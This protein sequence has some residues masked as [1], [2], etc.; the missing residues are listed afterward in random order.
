MSKFEELSREQQ[1]AFVKFKRG[2]NLFVTGAGGTGKTKLI[3]YIVGYIKNMK[4]RYQ[5]CAM[6]GCAA[7]LLA[8]YG[9]RTIHSWSGLRIPRGPR[10]QIVDR[11][12]RSKYS[13]H[14]WN[15]IDVLIVDEVSMMS[16][17]FFELLNEV[18]KLIRRK[19]GA[20]GGLQLIFLGDFYQLPPIPDADDP[21]SGRFCFESQKWLDVFPKNS[22]IELKTY[23]RQT[24][25]KYIEIL[26]QVRKGKIDE[27]NAEFLK[28]YVRREYNIEKM[29]GIVPM[30]LFPVRSR[31]D[32]INSSRFNELTG[33]TNVYTYKWTRNEKF[34]IDNTGA[35]TTPISVESITTCHALSEKEVEIEV[36]GLL[37]NINGAKETVLKVGAVVMCT[38]NLSISTGIC[39]GS[40]GIIVDFVAPAGW[41]EKMPVVKF[42]NGVVLTITP[43][44]RQSDVY[45]CIVVKQIPLCLAWAMTIHKIQG[46]TLSMAKM[47]IGTRIFE[48]GQTYVALSRIK[49]L[50]GLYL[51]DFH[52]N[53]IRANPKVDE[54][55]ASFVAWDTARID[56]FIE[57][58]KS[59]QHPKA[60]FT[61][62]DTS[63]MGVGM[64]GRPVSLGTQQK[65]TIVVKKIGSD[66]P[67][68]FT[69][70][71]LKKEDYN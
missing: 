22:H 1:Y 2:E 45:P 34:Y 28:G 43:F 51:T 59:I 32:F 7:V 44:A 62:N 18:G 6:T 50:D 35:K 21:S 17:K 69:A 52:P 16:E 56:E 42:T 57:T 25:P 71:E 23:F 19:S 54:F 20:F 38:T 13:R 33:D 37:A 47:D 39:N 55:Y 12:I 63:P 53:K 26:E 30:E 5:V 8:E 70:F 11:V 58:Y 68:P 40:Q 64:I 9:S 14:E 67:N 65:R 27:K 3:E 10:Q 29:G 49:T 15:A 66:A 61:V 48:F 24:D 31:V 36:D 60:T 4:M 46:S 41:T